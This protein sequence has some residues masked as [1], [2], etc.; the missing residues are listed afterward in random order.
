MRA[1]DAH[2]LH[3]DER[4][5]PWID[6]GAEQLK[7][8]GA[9][10]R[11]ARGKD[12]AVL[13]ENRAIPP[14]IEHQQH[15][16]VH[17]S[18]PFLETEATIEG[19]DIAQARLSFYADATCRADRRRVPRPKVAPNRQ[20]DLRSPAEGAMAPDVQAFEQFRVRDVTDGIPS[21]VGSHRKIL[22]KDR[23]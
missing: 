11:E 22:S 10:D 8:S 9:G 13:T 23:E 4:I 18:I 19:L 7:S 6:P 15:E 1:F 12:M 14:R 3:E 16:S 5:S 21:R 2:N 17:V 20:W